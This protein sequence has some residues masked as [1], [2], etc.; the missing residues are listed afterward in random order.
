MHIDNTWGGKIRSLVLKGNLPTAIADGLRPLLYRAHLC[1]SNAV[2]NHALLALTNPY[3]N[4]GAGAASCWSGGV[5]YFAPAVHAVVQAG[6]HA[7][8]LQH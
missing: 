7:A 4:D 8:S 5:F 3:K 6:V 2:V 1:W